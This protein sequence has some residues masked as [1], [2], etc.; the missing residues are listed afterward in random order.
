MTSRFE[1]ANDAQPPFQPDPPIVL[2]LLGGIAAG[3]STVAAR[4]AA[5]GLVHVDADQIAESVR[6]E[7]AIV[8]GLAREFGPKV[9]TADG[10][11]D[12]KAL[13]AIVFADP[14]ARR[15]LEA[16]THPAIRK[17][18][19]A[20]VERARDQGR[21]VLL[22]APLMLE[23]GLIEACQTVV[24]VE[25]SDARRQRRAEQ[26]G[27][28]EAEW[29]QRENAQAPLDEKRKRADF[30]ID[31]NG[32]MAA[33]QAQIDDLLQRLPADPGPTQ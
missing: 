3:K 14:K 15:Q 19:R 2:G 13:A 16:I 22:D 28:T 23:T 20:A 1:P 12:R 24:F 21:S 27:W 25:A 6:T 17:A 11:I 31:N 33:T 4:L 9:R 8:A 32:T 7:P 5:R 26:R 10:Q 18:I 29:R 30:T